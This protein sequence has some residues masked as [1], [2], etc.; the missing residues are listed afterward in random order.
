M[1]FIPPPQVGGPSYTDKALAANEIQMRDK[2]FPSVSIQH[3]FSTV[4]PPQRL[5][6]RVGVNRETVRSASVL[7]SHVSLTEAASPESHCRKQ[8]VAEAM[9]SCNAKHRRMFVG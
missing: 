3:F 8:N 1:S 5:R 6:S 2:I 9:R 7:T 4:T